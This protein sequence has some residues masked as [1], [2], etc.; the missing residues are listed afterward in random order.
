MLFITHDLG[1]V[2]KVADRILVMNQGKKVDEG[3]FLH[4]VRNASDPYTK[5]LVEK[6]LAV[7]EKYKTAIGRKGETE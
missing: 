1:A 3:D 5:L 6:R 2:S 4:I 7:M